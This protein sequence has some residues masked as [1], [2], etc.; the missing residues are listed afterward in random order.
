MTEIAAPPPL[1]RQPAFR[2]FWVGQSVSFVGDQ[3]S[4]LALP[5][6]GVF[7]LD[8]SAVEMG[9]LT[10]LGW[11]PHLVFSLFAGEW[12]D[13]RERRRPITISAEVGRTALLLRIVDPPAEAA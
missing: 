6:V 10:A 4:M 2:R 12:I 3:I 1:L 5:L 13:R 7:V 9:V 8:A 11:L